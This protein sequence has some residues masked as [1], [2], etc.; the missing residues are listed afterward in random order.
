MLN[1]NV[2]IL[3]GACYIT[4]EN[5]KKKQEQSYEKMGMTLITDAKTALQ[6]L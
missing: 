2:E 4:N 3:T 5:T 6:L 1:T